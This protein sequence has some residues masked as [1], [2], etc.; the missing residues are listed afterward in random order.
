VLGNQAKLRAGAAPGCGHYHHPAKP[1]I[2]LVWWRRPCV[3]RTIVCHGLARRTQEA[4]AFLLSPEAAE[5]RPL[6]VTEL[7]AALDLAARGAARSLA[8]RLRPE[9]RARAPGAAPA[10]GEGGR[11]AEGEAGPQ[12]RPAL[13]VPC[14]RLQPWWPARVLADQAEP[15][16]GRCV[17]G[18]VAQ[19][20]GCAKSGAPT[21]GDVKSWAWVP[22][23]DFKESA[24][25]G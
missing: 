11:A 16:T 14:A 23:S 1:D 12:R 9:A 10:G 19:R 20:G 5:L 6:L 24:M 22:H 3:Q 13:H 18:R 2:Y 25:G 7:V 21:C 17:S 15:G 4:L 8:A